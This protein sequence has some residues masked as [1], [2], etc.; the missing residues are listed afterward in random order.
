MPIRDGSLRAEDSRSK[1][2]SFSA[3]RDMRAAAENNRCWQDIWAQNL[4]DPL[5]YR[6]HD[7]RDCGLNDSMHELSILF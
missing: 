1:R 6:I 3:P 5:A 4:R 7:I 2:R